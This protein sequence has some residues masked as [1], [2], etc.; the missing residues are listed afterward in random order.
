MVMN[1]EVPAQA[2]KIWRRIIVREAKNSTGNRR[3]SVVVKMAKNCW[4]AKTIRIT[5]QATNVPIV[6]PEFH[7][8]VAPPKVKAMTKDV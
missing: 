4:R 3:R 8:Q 7:A 2:V 6:R 1:I 5:K